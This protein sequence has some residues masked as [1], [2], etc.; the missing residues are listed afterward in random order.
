MINADYGKDLKEIRKYFH[1]KGEELSKKAELNKLYIANIENKKTTY[2]RIDC[3]FRII[4]IFEIER[5][6]RN[7]S[8]EEMRETLGDN[9]YLKF[10]ELN[11]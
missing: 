7:I 5:T 11:S 1:L 10:M 9:I 2:P 8:Y 4:R 6:I 3:I